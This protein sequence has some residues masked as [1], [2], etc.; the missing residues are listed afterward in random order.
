ML[1]VV[2]Y[3]SGPPE[4]FILASAFL[5]VSETSSY[6]RVE[7][8]VPPHHRHAGD[9]QPSAQPIHHG[10]AISNGQPIDSTDPSIDH[11]PAIGSGP[12]IGEAGARGLRPAGA[13]TGHRPQGPRA[14]HAAAGGDPAPGDHRY[15]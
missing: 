11:G 15:Y 7:A 12:A 10:P 2:D 9:A 13:R 6:Y 14:R 3:Q 4:N 1:A 8:A 5:R